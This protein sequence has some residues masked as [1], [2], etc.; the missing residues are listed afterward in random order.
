M[1]RSKKQRYINQRDLLCLEKFSILPRPLICEV[2]RSLRSHVLYVERYPRGW[3]GGFAK[4]VG[5]V[6]LAR[7]FES[8][9]LRQYFPTLEN[10][11]KTKSTERWSSGLWQQSWKLSRLIASEGS[12]PSLSAIRFGLCTHELSRVVQKAPLLKV[13]GVFCFC[14]CGAGWGIM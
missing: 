10:T 2:K 9:P 1:R 11:C 14:G 12:N 4:P 8:P 6:Y 3:R 7:G 13:G 5:R